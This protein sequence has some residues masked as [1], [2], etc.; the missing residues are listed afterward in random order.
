MA[1]RSFDDFDGYAQNYRDIHSENV[2]LSGADSLYFA[3]MKVELLLAHESAGKPLHVLDLG[4]GDGAT[5]VFMQQHFPQWKVWGIDVS[6]KSI[7]AATERQL[8]NVV[9]KTYDGR[10]LPFDD[11]F[12]DL[13]FVAGVLHHVAFSL[14]GA[15]VGEINRVLKRGGRLYLFEHNPLNP[16]TRYLVN[17]CVFDKDAKLLKSG[18][19]AQLLRRHQLPETHL[20]FIIFFPRKGWLSRLIFLEPVLK[21]IPLGGQY[22]LRSVKTG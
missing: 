18:Y 7:E 17:T 9:Y 22:Y 11:V 15:V 14:H 16:L 20:H 4:C 12:F 1:E 10:H 19:T 2:K 8:P 5:Q 3:N 21:K 6:A 13:V